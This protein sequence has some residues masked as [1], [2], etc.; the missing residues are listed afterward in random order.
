MNQQQLLNTIWNIDAPSQPGNDFESHLFDCKGINI[1]RR[2]LLANAQRGLSITF[3]T[4]FKLLDSDI[5]EKLVYQFLK[6]CPPSQGDWAQWGEELSDFIAT[7]NIADDYPY[8][9]DCAALDWHIHC[10]LHGKDQVLDYSTLPLLSDVE[11]SNI[12][13]QF[14]HNVA[15]I[16]THYPLS[17]IFDAHHHSDDSVRKSAMRNAQ[18]LLSNKPEERVVMIFRPEFQPKVV[19]LSASERHFMLSLMAG[20]SLATSLDTINDYPDFS[21]EQ[22]LIIGIERNLINFFKET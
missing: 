11:P 14:N 20:K 21:F 13:V 2:N 16:N 15:L 5:A 6:F 19:T 12:G 1:Y 4:V 22:W 10:A 8:L 3:P 7:T 9:P 18:V 17:E